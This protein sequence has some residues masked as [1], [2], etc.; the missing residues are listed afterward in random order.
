MTR[1]PP[2][3]RPGRGR[4]PRRRKNSDIEKLGLIALA[5]AV[6]LSL[7]VGVLR[8]LAEHPWVVVLALLAAAVASGVWV[9]RRKE[10][11]QWERVRSQGLRY[12]VEQLDRLHHRQFEFAVR[13][14]M[15]RDG[16]T[17]AQQVGGRGDNGA[18]VK[19][20]D[21]YGRRWV[22][23]CKH[24][25]AGW[26]GKPVGTPDLHVLNGTG[27]QIHGGDVLVMLTNGRITTNATD[28]AKSQHLHLVDRHLLAQ[29][30]A[31]SRPLWELL[32]AVPPPRKPTSLS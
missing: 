22:I 16:C 6:A 24:R 15:H 9:W 20:T 27:R 25:K 23:Q 26:A 2:A 3:R 14:L 29:W 5:G 10:A 32:R 21:P 7:V 28:F 17:D 13:D 1:R 30:A 31:G 8:W 12:A 4:R 11:A 18:D 19:A